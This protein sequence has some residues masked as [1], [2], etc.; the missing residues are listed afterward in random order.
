[1][2][3][4]Q[5]V[6]KYREKNQNDID[7]K[8]SHIDDNV[9]LNSYRPLSDR[10]IKD[11]P[12]KFLHNFVDDILKDKKMGTLLYSSNAKKEIS[13]ITRENAINKSTKNQKTSKKENITNNPMDII[14]SRV[15]R[16]T[17]SQ[18][19]V[20]TA[21]FKQER[22]D[23]KSIYDSKCEGLFKS[24]RAEERKKKINYEESKLSNR[25]DRIEKVFSGI[26]EKLNTSRGSKTDRSKK[27]WLPEV[28][29]NV[30]DV[31]S[32]LY[33][34]AV[35]PTESSVNDLNMFKDK[36]TSKKNETS[37]KQK[38]NFNI[39]NVIES[40]NGKEFTI[41]ITEEIV[42]KCL[43]RNSGGP[44]AIE[45]VIEIFIFKS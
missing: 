12:N 2:L 39:K 26:R 15:K 45:N 38:N 1:M 41:K 37:I 21:R 25:K 29:L 20:E 42:L 28:K 13:L 22:S 18:I 6:Y 3:R 16:E 9:I 43:C 31:Y 5:Y 7:Y 11:I 10:S 44:T 33:Y 32:R 36:I 19:T 34:N 35:L 8:I 17:I 30:N 4:N 27:I 40:S 24:I 14:K 23:L